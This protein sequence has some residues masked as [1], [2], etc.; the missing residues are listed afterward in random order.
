MGASIAG[1]AGDRRLAIRRQAERRRD[2]AAAG[3]PAQTR[4]IFGLL[5]R[6]VSDFMADDCMTMS[7]ALSYY[8]V[9]SLPS[10]LLLILL[11]LGAILSPEDVRGTIET[12]INTLMGPAGAD[13]V[14]SILAHAHAPGGNLPATLVGV[15]ILLLGATGA[16]GQLQQALNR[17]WGVKPNPHQSGYKALLS[18]RLLA[19]GMILVIAFLLLVSLVIS[20]VLSAFGRTLGQML[21]SGISG[22]VLWA[23]DAALSIGVITVLFA[24]MFVVLPDAKIRWKDV[25][26]GALLTTLLFLVGKYLLGFYLAHS[27]PAQAFGAASSLALMFLW[28]Y[29]S[30]IILFFG[31][32]FTEKWAER[33]GGIRPEHGAMRVERIERPVEAPAP[34]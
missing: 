23:I 19:A 2:V 17:I 7:A 28:I 31:A 1:H 22:A 9:F 24:A 14:R 27:N 3:V 34:S 12:Q 13:Q 21:G 20:A 8:T 18:K 25:W 16:F 11:L 15:G 26:V 6:T 30:S 32:E 10:L 5:K 29:Y 33:H 4:G